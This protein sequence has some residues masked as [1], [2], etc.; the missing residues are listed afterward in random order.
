MYYKKHF[1][2]YLIKKGMIKMAETKNA[3]AT[4]K[5]KINGTVYNLNIKTTADAI[6][7]EDGSI[8]TAL[9]NIIANQHANQRH[10]P[11]ITCIP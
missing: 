6:S 4:L 1:N 11:H 3:K 8:K 5:K 7:Y 9:D 2:K 10:C